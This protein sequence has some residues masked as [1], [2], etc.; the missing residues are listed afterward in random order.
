[1]CQP[2]VSRSFEMSD[3]STN[4]DGVSS[5]ARRRTSPLQTVFFCIL[6]ERYTLSS[7]RLTLALQSAQYYFTSISSSNR[8]A[9]KMPSPMSPFWPPFLLLH[10]AC[11]VLFG[12]GFLI[13]WAIENGS[14]WAELLQRCYAFSS[15]ELARYSQWYIQILKII[16]V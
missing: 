11:L 7:Q 2:P 16:H 1:M 3:I 9:F 13:A 6:C 4:N 5:P 14:S 8:S 15:L 12:G 10:R